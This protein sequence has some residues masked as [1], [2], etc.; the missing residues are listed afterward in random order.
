M[1]FHVKIAII[2]ASMSIL[3]FKHTQLILDAQKVA[4]PAFKAINERFARRLPPGQGVKLRQVSSV[5]TKV[6]PASNFPKAGRLDKNQLSTWF[7]FHYN[8]NCT[9][10]QT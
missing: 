10:V 4:P 1:I 6:S 7:L 3:S 2:G 8:Y 9:T 5:N